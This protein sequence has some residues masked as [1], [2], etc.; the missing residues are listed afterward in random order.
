MAAPVRTDGGAPADDVTLVQVGGAVGVLV[1]SVVGVG[2]R[3]EAVPL[4]FAVDLSP[5]RD[6]ELLAV[7][8][9]PRTEVVVT[10]GIVEPNTP[11]PGDR[12]NFG[13]VTALLPLVRTPLR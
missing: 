3:P 5:S 11:N 8:V 10:E 7:W 12:L 1:A 4:P 9:V 13:A 2:I 6:D